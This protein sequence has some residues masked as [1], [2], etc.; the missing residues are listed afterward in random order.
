M[1]RDTVIYVRFTPWGR[2]TDVWEIYRCEYQGRS[3]DLP[4]LNEVREEHLEYHPDS[5]IWKCCIK[6]KD[7]VKTMLDIVNYTIKEYPHQFVVRE[8]EKITLG[9]SMYGI[10]YHETEDGQY[11]TPGYLSNGGD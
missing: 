7:I 2:L 11:W 5:M 10:Q 3:Q 1:S 9:I 4:G 8:L 6:E